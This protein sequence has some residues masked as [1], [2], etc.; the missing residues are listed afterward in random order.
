MTKV[1]LTVRETITTDEFSNLT[2][3]CRRTTQ[4]LVASG[5]L[6]SIKLGGRR[7]ILARPL[8]DRLR[9]SEAVGANGMPT[10]F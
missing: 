10:R 8:R 1:D 3:L 7:L 4:S 5:E 9:L 2:G 6:E